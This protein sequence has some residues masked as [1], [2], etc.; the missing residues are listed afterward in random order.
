MTPTV[1]P[2]RRSPDWAYLPSA[3]T[4]PAF[5][6]LDHILRGGLRAT[7]VE[8]G[9]QFRREPDG[10]IRWRA[11]ISP[12]RLVSALRFGTSTQGFRADAEERLANLLDKGLDAGGMV[13]QWKATHGM[14]ES[15]WAQAQLELLSTTDPLKVLANLK[16]GPELVFYRLRSETALWR[17]LLLWEAMTELAS[18]TP[19]QRVAET[20][21]GK[22]NFAV[23]GLVQMA[24]ASIVCGPLL[25]R[26]EPLGAV[27]MTDG[28][29]Q[30]VVLLSRGTFRRPIR[31]VDWPIGMTRISFAGPGRGTHATEVK[32]FDA[33]HA[34]RM[35]LL[36]TDGANRLLDY[37]TSPQNWIRADTDDVV[38]L[39][40]R[41]MTWSS[42]L[43]G[44]DAIASL[45]ATW[46]GADP[47]WVAFRAL[48][49]LQ[50]IWNG[51][52]HDAVLLDQLLDPRLIKKH[53]VQVLPEG[54][55]RSWASGIIDNYELDLLAAFPGH[56]LEDILKKIAQV[57][58]LVHGV[59]GRSGSTVRL[60]VLRHLE[61][62]TPNLQLINEVAAF[63]WTA[64]LL[65]PSSHCR[66]GSAPWESQQLQ[67][68]RRRTA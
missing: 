10:R 24:P 27:L 16:S 38:D 7:F 66:V 32:A 61:R 64:V 44:L 49:V 31:L 55:E 40:G 67:I 54:Q 8:A 4:T 53:A 62:A 50:G 21:Q 23:S 56:K 12:P 13:Q 41:W 47:L 1:T 39:D 63:W 11:A 51:D 29:V 58:N 25:A 35:L 42:V 34:E 14:E 37:L 9:M 45:G 20:F 57:R 2:T 48:G 33:G 59:R 65:S 3:I 43:F 52:R 15:L 46:A 30:V 28:A 6:A 22:R 5:L 68:T 17:R 60:E 19:T 18:G 36:A 26:Q